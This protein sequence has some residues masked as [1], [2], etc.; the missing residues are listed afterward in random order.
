MG[1]STVHDQFSVLEQ[2]ARAGVPVDV[3]SEGNLERELAY[4]NHSSAD[5]HAI[6]V[7][8]KAIGDVKT[9]RVIV[10]PARLAGMVRGLRVNPA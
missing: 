6:E 3:G 10:V 2:I 9:G 1:I 8:E 5:R 4:D 7:L